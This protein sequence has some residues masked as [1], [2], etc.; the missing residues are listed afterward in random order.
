[1]GKAYTYLRA[2]GAAL[3][4]GN[5]F[6]K[7]WWSQNG[8]DTLLTIVL[9]AGTFVTNFFPTFEG[10]IFTERDPN[11][12]FPLVEETVTNLV[13][14]LI[15]G[16]VPWAAVLCSQLLMRFREIDNVYSS[17]LTASQLGL[18]QAL[19]FSNLFTNT[20]KAYVGR[21]RPNFFALCDYK[22]FVS[23]SSWYFNVTVPGRQMEAGI[24]HDPNARQSFPSGHSSN[25]FA[26]L[27]YLSLFWFGALSDSGVP[28]L[29][30]LCIMSAP[31]FVGSFVAASRTRDYFHNYDDVCAG[32]AI[33]M[34]CAGATFS[35][36]FR[37]PISRTHRQLALADTIS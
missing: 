1:L 11:L 13:L 19:A 12:S 23:N 7:T 36:H 4:M 35:A 33:G 21:P 8:Y 2:G 16:L 29:L 18:F 20:F 30:K 28:K 15:A 24:C 32:A 3:Q 34:L 31:I 22:G 14:G 5:T 37:A 25:S 6:W 10:R 17:S 27:F 26:G 9:F